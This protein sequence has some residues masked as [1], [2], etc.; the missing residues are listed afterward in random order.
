[1]AERVELARTV[2]ALSGP[3]GKEADGGLPGDKACRL[4]EKWMRVSAF[5]C[6]WHFSGL[7]ADIVRDCLNPSEPGSPDSHNVE[8]CR[9]RVGQWV[10]PQTRLLC[11]RGRQACLG[12]A[13][14]GVLE[15][16]R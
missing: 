10:G 9:S 3:G 13:P 7:M 15:R 5:R 2:H 12:P 11:H 6:D 1:M 8:R 4:M 16:F 14:P